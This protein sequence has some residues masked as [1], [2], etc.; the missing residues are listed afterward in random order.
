MSSIRP[1]HT[2]DYKA[3]T[4]YAVGT[5]LSHFSALISYL[6]WFSIESEGRTQAKDEE[7]GSTRNEALTAVGN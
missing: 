7:T 1:C 4:K 5:V 6:G 3:C 2:Q